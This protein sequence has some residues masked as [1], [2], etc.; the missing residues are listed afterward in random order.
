MPH[1]H[2]AHDWRFRWFVIALCCGCA[3]L[4]VARVYYIL[5]FLPRHYGFFADAASRLIDFDGWLAFVRSAPG[6]V[7]HLAA[8]ACFGRAAA[9]PFFG[10][11]RGAS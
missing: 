8:V 4:F 3:S 9:I 7:L 1:Y 6:L 11:H 10:R 2:A 5:V